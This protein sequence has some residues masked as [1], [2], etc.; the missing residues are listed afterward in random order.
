MA[1]DLS[2]VVYGWGPVSL[3]SIWLYQEE[4]EK[5]LQCE[6]VQWEHTCA[7]CLEVMLNP[8]STVPCQHNFCECCLRRLTTINTPTNTKCPLCRQKIVRC[9]RNAGICYWVWV[10]DLLGQTCTSVIKKIEEFGPGRC[11]LK[12]YQFGVSRK[13][14]KRISFTFCGC[15]W[16]LRKTDLLIQGFY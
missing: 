3:C 6:V 14:S 7:M 1:G 15:D 10:T 13:S 8:H 11:S 5:S 2:H 16:K 9:L 4:Q 12:F